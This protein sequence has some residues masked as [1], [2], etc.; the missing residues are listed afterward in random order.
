VQ[1]CSS[2]LTPQVGPGPLTRLS[3]ASHTPLTRLTTL[4]TPP[5]LYRQGTSYFANLNIPTCSQSSLQAI[6]PNV[7]KASIPISRF[8]LAS[9]F[10]TI[11]TTFVVFNNTSFVLS[12]LPRS[13]ATLPVYTNYLHWLPSVHHPPSTIQPA[14]TCDSAGRARRPA[15]EA[16]RLTPLHGIRCQTFTTQ[17]HDTVPA[18]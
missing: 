6:P 1:W 13:I 12:S 7:L 11:L 17:L 3:H 10:S 16:I 2:N 14:V 8:L 5:P 4:Y 15:P 18:R 9:Y